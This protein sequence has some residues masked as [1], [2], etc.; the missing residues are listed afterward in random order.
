[1]LD[2]NESIPSRLKRQKTK[3]VIILIIII[4]FCCCCFW[5]GIITFNANAELH[6]TFNNSVYQNKQKL[7]TLIDQ[8]FKKTPWPKWGTRIDK[9]EKLALDKL[10][11]PSGGDRPGATNVMLIFTDGEPTGLEES[12]FTPFT[13]LRRGLEVKKKTFPMYVFLANPPLYTPV[14]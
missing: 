12:D 1:M 11:S 2:R 13:E 7:K 3:N 14:I 5:I 10:F 6:N 8:K 9:A 4:V